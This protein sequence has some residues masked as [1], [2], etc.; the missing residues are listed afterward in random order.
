MKY[1][2]I[3]F[4]LPSY[5][6][7]GGLLRF[8][9]SA[10]A[11]ADDPSQLRFT[12]LANI[13][14]G[15]TICRARDLE[16]Q[17]PSAY[18]LLVE[19][20]VKPNLSSYYN[21]IYRDTRWQEENTLVSMVADDMEWQT[22]G[23]DTAILCGVNLRDGIAIV[24]CNDAYVQGRKMCVNLFTTRRY[25]EATNAPFMCPDFASKYMDAVWMMI[26]QRTGSLLYLEDVILKH[27]HEGAKPA[28][29]RSETFKRMARAAMA[30]VTGHAIAR[31]AAD[32]IV[33]NLGKALAKQVAK[34]KRLI[35]IAVW[36]SDPVYVRGAIENVYWFRRCY[37]GWKMRFYVADNVPAA[38]VD[39]LRS[40][41]DDVE[42]VVH[43]FDE[44][45]KRLRRLEAGKDE[46]YDRVVFRDADGRAS[47]R[48][49]DA[50][51]EWI[52]SG[53]PFHIMRD[54]PKHTSPIMGG[55]CGAKTAFLREIGFPSM[56]DEWKAA[57][58]A[59][60]APSNRYSRFPNSDQSFL[61]MRMWPL[62]ADHACVHDDRGRFG[63]CRKFRRA[64]PKGFFVGQPFRPLGAK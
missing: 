15:D 40:Q 9:E 26:G 35:S 17:N 38:A 36:G 16:S 44:R 30:P 62:V 41:G 20:S 49:S 52:E 8:I 60:G 10:N 23:Y 14:D 39:E 43:P 18:Q 22:K 57:V 55:I 63:P 6:R 45:I 37:P 59:S 2:A 7:L 4:F 47:V 1:S 58:V 25:V 51:A 33:A 42:A 64:L 50:V 5:R 34:E 11:R 12:I 32:K 31:K 13:S 24:Y 27:W 29:Q 3:N 53:L 48:E 46:S 54:H 56:F 19:D 61:S 21:R 28:P